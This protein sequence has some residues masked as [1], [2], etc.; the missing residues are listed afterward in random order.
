MLPSLIT[1]KHKFRETLKFNIVINLSSTIFLILILSIFSNQILLAYGDNYL[2]TRL[3]IILISSTIFSSLSSV[4]GSSIASLGLMWF[5]FG[6]NL[7]WSFYMIIF[8]VY[9]VNIGYGA[10]GLAYALFLSYFIHSISQLVF[11]KYLRL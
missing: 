3:F 5:G 10:I 6:F 2:D 7:S 1:Y 4:V 8:T 9:F 11:L